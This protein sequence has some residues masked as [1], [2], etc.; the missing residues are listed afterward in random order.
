MPNPREPINILLA[1]GRKHLTQEEIQRI[2]VHMLNDLKARLEPLG[3]SLEF[4]QEAVNTV[5]KT[6]FDPVYGA[7][8]LRREIQ[9]K[10]EDPLSEQLLA[11]GLQAGKTVVCDASDGKIIFKINQKGID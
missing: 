1:K 11:G 6:G 7:R 10:I 4:T 8:P 3:V 5:A 9:T 2:A